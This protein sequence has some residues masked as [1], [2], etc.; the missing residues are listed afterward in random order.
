[1]P[2]KLQAIDVVK[3]LS[4]HPLSKKIG[5]GTAERAHVDELVLMVR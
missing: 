1:M 4:S 3:V 2:Y 5:V